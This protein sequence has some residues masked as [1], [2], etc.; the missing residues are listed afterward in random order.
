MSHALELAAAHYHWYATLAAW[1]NIGSLIAGC[2]AV[3]LAIVAIS[4]GTAGL[5]DWRDKQQAQ[6][7]LADEEKLSIRLD[8]QRVLNGWSPHGLPVY[9]VE[10][11]TE[12]AEMTQAQDELTSGHPTRYVILRVSEGGSDEN[13]ANQLRQLVDTTGF[14]TRP[15]ERGEYE[16]IEAGRQALLRG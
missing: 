6:K 13:R 16:A 12:P 10:L 1:G 11:V 7:A 4:T 5:S 15:P 8:R 3:L 2:A 14:L 9:G